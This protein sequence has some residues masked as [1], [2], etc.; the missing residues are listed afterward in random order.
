MQVQVN[1][2]YINH[3]NGSKITVTK[4]HKWPS[5]TQRWLFD[6]ICENTGKSYSFEEDTLLQNYVLE[7][8]LDTFK[9]NLQ[10]A[11]LSD[12]QISEMKREYMIAPMKEHRTNCLNATGRNAFDDESEYKVYRHFASVKGCYILCENGLIFKIYPDY[13][14]SQAIIKLHARCTT[15]WFADT[16]EMIQN[17][18]ELTF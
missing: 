10:S 1:Q 14:K 7:N 6:V 13:E 11:E 4:I 18:D 17:V 5:R 8:E 2:T 9:Q 15:E 16:V 3:Y 12:E